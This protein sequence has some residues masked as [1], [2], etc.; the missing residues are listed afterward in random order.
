[1]Y[2]RWKTTPNKHFWCESEVLLWT[3]QA[4]LKYNAEAAVLCSCCLSL[5]IISYHGCQYIPGTQFTGVSVTILFVCM[6]G[7]LLYTAV[8]VSRYVRSKIFIPGIRCRL[9]VRI[10][11]INK[12]K[13]LSWASSFPWIERVGVGNFRWTVTSG[14]KVEPYIISNDR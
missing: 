1:M 7:W 4:A 12:P 8:Q 6:I 9:P 13:P 2:F 14:G 10:Y 5:R 11:D 3:K